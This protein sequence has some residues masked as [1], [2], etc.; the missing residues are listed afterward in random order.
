MPEKVQDYLATEEF[1]DLVKRDYAELVQTA[2][3]DKKHFTFVDAIE[4]H[5]DFWEVGR[6]LFH[7]P[8]HNVYIPVRNTIMKKPLMGDEDIIDDELGYMYNNYDSK[9]K[10]RQ[11]FSPMDQLS[12]LRSNRMGP[13]RPR[14]IDSYHRRNDNARGVTSVKPRYFKFR[15]L[16]NVKDNAFSTATR[17]YTPTPSAMQDGMVRQGAIGVSIPTRFFK[18]MSPFRQE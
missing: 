10:T 7:L 4:E 16:S 8:T 12:P 1:E 17:A 18:M 15:R 6:D 3:L 11:R 5:M 2:L 13:G 14:V 9:D